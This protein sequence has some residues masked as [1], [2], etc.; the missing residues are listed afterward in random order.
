MYHVLLQNIGLQSKHIFEINKKYNKIGVYLFKFF[1]DESEC[2]VDGI[3]VTSYC[4]N[5]FGARTIAYVDLSTT[6]K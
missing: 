5:A 6:L 2:L 4:N 3:S 1:A